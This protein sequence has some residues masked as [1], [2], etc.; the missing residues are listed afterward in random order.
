MERKYGG[1][2]RVGLRLAVAGLLLLLI[3]ILSVQIKEIIVTGNGRYTDQQMIDLIFPGQRD[4]NAAYSYYKDKVRPHVKIPFV[5]DYKIVWDGPQQVEII[6]Y[7]KNVVG[8]VSYMSSYMY[9]DKD[10]IIV[11][12]TGSRIGGVPLITGLEFGQVVLYQPLP[13]ES[14]EIFGEILNLTQVLSIYKMN[15]DKIQYNSYGEATL[16]LDKL[17]VVIGSNE[18]LNGKIAELHDMLPQLENL[19]GT[20][21]LD[22]FSEKGTKAMFRFQPK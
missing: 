13:V 18:E 15:V 3:L 7:E 9:F 19:T 12:S 22:T 8:Y 16:Y 14:S 17:E 5:E 20:L 4:R 21:Y 11:E 6:V 2:R 1:K 10:G